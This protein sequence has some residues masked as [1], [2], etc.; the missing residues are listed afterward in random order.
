MEELANEMVELAQN[1]HFN[2]CIGSTHCRGNLMDSGLFV[3]SAHRISHC[4]RDHQ[5]E[6]AIASDLRLQ[7]R[8]GEVRERIERSLSVLRRPEQTKP[9]EIFSKRFLD[10]FDWITR[11]REAVVSYAVQYQREF[12]AEPYNPLLL[13][14]LNQRN[15]ADV[16][17]CHDT[18]IG[19]LIKDLL[20]EFPDMTVREF[21]VLVPGVQLSGLK[22]RYVVGLLSRDSRYFDAAQGWKISDKEMARILRDEY[23]LDV[24]RRAVSNYRQWVD[25][26]LLK[27]RRTSRDETETES[28]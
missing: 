19:R 22:G 12:L 27:R 2:A 9:Q 24:Q 4:A 7:S 6:Y 20:I 26:H 15:L 25:D 28:E 23:Q 14:E 18:T 3:E 10:E 1:G 13:R 5:P 21:A 11:N 17:C 16:I 8:T